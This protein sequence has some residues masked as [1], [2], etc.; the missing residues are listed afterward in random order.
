MKK[1][2]IMDDDPLVRSMLKMKLEDEGYDVEEATNGK[3][4]IL[5][6]KVNRPDVVIIDLLM[7]EKE[8]VETIQE[9]KQF[10]PDV[11]LIAIS[12]GGRISAEICLS[13]AKNLGAA[14]TFEKPVDNE[15]LLQ[16]IKDLT[17]S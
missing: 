6:F 16:A 3:E 5:N 9:L 14:Y 13:M 2:L 8:G 12:G 10:Y 7:P 1:I 17:K 15:K 4:G 11:N